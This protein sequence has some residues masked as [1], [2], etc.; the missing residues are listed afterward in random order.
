VTKSQ[1]LQ[2]ASKKS[3][4]ASSPDP[5]LSFKQASEHC[6]K[7]PGFNVTR[8]YNGGASPRDE[9]RRLDGGS[10]REGRWQWASNCDYTSGLAVDIIAEPGC[11]TLLYGSGTHSFDDT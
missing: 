2:A 5:G 10:V 1:N 3:V 7:P 6:F 4:W 11:I 9:M 8:K